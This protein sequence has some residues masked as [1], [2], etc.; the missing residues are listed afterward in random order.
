M[1]KAKPEA[2][3]AAA[4]KAAD[5]AEAEQQVVAE[6][7]AEAKAAAE[8]EAESAEDAEARARYAQLE[9]ERQAAEG[10]PPVVTTAVAPVASIGSRGEALFQQACHVYG[11]DPNPDVRPREVLQWKFYPETVDTPEHVTLVTAGGQKLSFPPDEPT[12]E[13]LRQ[14]FRVNRVN[15]KGERVEGVLP[16]DL[17]LPL[18]MITGFPERSGAHVYRRGYLREGGKAE[19]NRRDAAGR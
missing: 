8:D 7:K 17:A 6:E 5:K 11:I 19:A 16:A 15:E 13:K 18:P 10:A 9:K 4:E 1:A 2:A 14:I 3:T 12:F